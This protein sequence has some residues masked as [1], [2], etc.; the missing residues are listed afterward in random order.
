MSRL[1]ELIQKLCPNGVEYKTLS[2]LFNTRNGY[3]PS[4]SNPEFWKNGTSES[5][6]PFHSI[7]LLYMTLRQTEKNRRSLKKTRQ[8]MVQNNNK[9]LFW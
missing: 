1:D 2:D 7:S 6:V 8:D 5:E 3:T 9:I 4:K